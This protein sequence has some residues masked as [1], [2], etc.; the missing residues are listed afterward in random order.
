M[1]SITIIPP[2]TITSGMIT[3][4]NVA[5]S[6]NRMKAFDT[7][8]TSQTTNS[9]TITYEILPGQIVNGVAVLNVSANS[10]RVRVDDP[11]DGVVYDRTIT[12]AGTI[13]AS[14]WW[15]YFFATV[16]PATQALFTDLPAYGSAS[17]MIDIDAGSDTAAV[18][19]IVIGQQI[20]LPVTVQYGASI[21]ALDFSRKETDEFGDLTWIKRGNSR[22]VDLP[23]L[24]PTDM[25]DT[26][27][28]ILADQGLCVWIMDT[29]TSNLTVYGW[30][31]DLSTVISY[32]RISDCNIEI[33][34]LT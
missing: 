16:R 31:Q 30:Y 28:D 15:Q 11:T 5:D 6:T 27:M 10:V 9:G 8:T 24:I 4:S 14:D 7:S 23:C 25:V 1:N 2:V 34:R 18:G 12:L 32:P 17:V 20:T 3:A 26:V 22:L 29:I 19:V 21:R 33:Q 13:P